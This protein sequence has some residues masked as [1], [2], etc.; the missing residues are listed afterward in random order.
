MFTVDPAFSVYHLV[1]RM[2]QQT[3]LFNHR[4][5]MSLISYEIENAT[6][7]DAVRV[8]VFAGFQYYSKF[9]PQVKRY[10]KL[11]M[12]A[13]SVYVFGV[14]DVQPPTIPNLH[15]IPLTTADQLAKEWFLIAHGVDYSSALATEEVS[16]FTDPDEQRQFKGIW[17]FDVAIV[18]IMHDWLTSLVD[19]RPFIE[20]A[21]RHDQERHRALIGTSLR[22]LNTT[23]GTLNPA[24]TTH[25]ELDN[26]VKASG[27]DE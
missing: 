11:A 4:R 15:Y 21:N 9:M 3:V 14:P 13:E 5:T 12:R 2:Q 20:A 24:A 8:R 10:E 22:R 23:I 27:A 19:A 1:E 6:L 17:T 18:T 25:S 7:I 16:R 26:A